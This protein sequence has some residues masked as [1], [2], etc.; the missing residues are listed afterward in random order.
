MKNIQTALQN[1]NLQNKIKV[2]TTHASEYVIGNALIPPSTGVFLEYVKETMVSVL[3]F[4][5]NNRAPSMVN[6]YPI[7][8]YANENSRSISLEYALF[9]STSAVMKDGNTATQTCLMPWLILL[10]R[11]WKTWDITI[12]RSS[13]LKADGLLLA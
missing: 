1:A 11:P 9:K 3:K 5:Y 12:F 10:S 7:F 8:S 13:L 2:S 4:L 6:V